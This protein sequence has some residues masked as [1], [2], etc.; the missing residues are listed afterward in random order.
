MGQRTCLAIVRQHVG[1]LAAI[2]SRS[3]ASSEDHLIR[4]VSFADANTHLD[5]LAIAGSTAWPIAAELFDDY[6]ERGEHFAMGHLALSL[7]DRAKLEHAADGAARTEDGGAGLLDALIRAPAAR[8][9]AAIR[10]WLASPDP[11][12]RLLAA[13]TL[14]GHRADP[15]PWLPSLLADPDPRVRAE[16]ARLAG[17]VERRDAAPRLAEMLDDP[18]PPVRFRAAE[19]LV[20]QGRHPAAEAELRAVAARADA[21]ATTAARALA[22]RLPP[23]ET[24]AWLARLHADPAT[25]AIAVRGLGMLGDRS[26]LPW[27]IAQMTDRAVAMPAAAAFVELNGPLDDFDEYFEVHEEEIPEGPGPIPDELEWRM[28][29]P[30][31]F[32]AL[33]VEG[34]TENLEARRTERRSPARPSTPASTS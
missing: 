5:A 3:S 24:R 19:A 32:E 14:R 20:A 11:L 15:G 30:A 7:S 23:A 4:T 31:M 25:R 1:E 8:S 33:L 29:I 17:A 27:L 12:R 6:P 18:H 2:W 26:V 9:A 22:L 28:P 16:A 21:D 13:G 34:G 10:D